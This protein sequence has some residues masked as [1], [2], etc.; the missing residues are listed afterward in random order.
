[1]IC[2]LSTYRHRRAGFLSRIRILYMSVV[3]VPELVMSHVSYHE[4][5]LDEAILWTSLELICIRFFFLSIFSL[6]S[7][8]RWIST[9]PYFNLVFDLALTLTYSCCVDAYMRRDATWSG[10]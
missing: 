7:L 8:D 9:T 1:M 4:Y 5:S 3:L 10:V 6:S 2:H